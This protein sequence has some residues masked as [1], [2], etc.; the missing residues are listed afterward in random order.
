MLSGREGTP[1]RDPHWYERL[2]KSSQLGTGCYPSLRTGITYPP[3]FYISKTGFE[4]TR[5]IRL[6]LTAVSNASKLR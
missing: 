5:V 4:L 6:D 2:V 1:A 3:C